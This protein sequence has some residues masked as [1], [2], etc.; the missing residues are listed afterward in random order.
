ML[1]L[2]FVFIL[3]CQKT[4]YAENFISEQLSES[5]EK[6]INMIQ[7]SNSSRTVEKNAFTTGLFFVALGFR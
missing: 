4:V 1:F 5:D 3:I 7:T 6:E 2:L